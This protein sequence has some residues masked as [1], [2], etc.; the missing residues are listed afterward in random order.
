MQPSTFLL[1]NDWGS[2][3]SSRRNLSTWFLSVAS[4]VL[5][6]RGLIEMFE[7]RCKPIQAE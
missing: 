1:M 2:D 5:S 3:T 7:S 6:K 4:G